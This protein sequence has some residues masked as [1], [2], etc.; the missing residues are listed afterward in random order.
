MDLFSSFL[1]GSNDAAEQV[2][3]PGRLYIVGARDRQSTFACGTHVVSKDLALRPWVAATQ[4]RRLVS[5]ALSRGV[6]LSC[7][8]CSMEEN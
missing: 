8:F 4:R 7:L 3:D 6:P 1:R 2:L 5:Q